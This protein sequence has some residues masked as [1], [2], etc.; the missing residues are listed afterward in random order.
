MN[1]LAGI[2]GSMKEIKEYRIEYTGHVIHLP[3]PQNPA[4]LSGSLLQAETF[5]T[6]EREAGRRRDDGRGDEP[7][8][9]PKSRTG[10]PLVRPRGCAPIGKGA[11]SAGQ[12]GVSAEPGSASTP[13]SG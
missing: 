5:R 11:D 6:S 3:V 1:A 7:A 12:P 2:F 10:E 4:T 9:V 8:K 13:S